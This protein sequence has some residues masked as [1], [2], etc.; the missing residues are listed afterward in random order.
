MQSGSRKQV[1]VARLKSDV[2]SAGVELLSA[3]CATDR[4]R[5]QYS[6]EDIIAHGDRNILKRAITSAHALYK[7]FSEIDADIRH[8]D[9]S[10]G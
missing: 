6:V 10:R 7:F 3:Q 2:A 4:V 9:R 5:L 1:D 8:T